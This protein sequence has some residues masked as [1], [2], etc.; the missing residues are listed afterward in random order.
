LYAFGIGSYLSSETGTRING[1]REGLIRVAGSFP[2]KVE[3]RRE[4]F[5]FDPNR[6]EED[7]GEGGGRE[8][9]DPEG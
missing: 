4:A 2:A 9:R 5:A 8:L 1:N 7:G 3:Q 6:Y